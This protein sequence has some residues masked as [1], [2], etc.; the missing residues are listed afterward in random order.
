MILNLEISKDCD[1]CLRFFFNDLLKKNA[2]K[3]IEILWGQL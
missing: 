2:V 1:M 3:K